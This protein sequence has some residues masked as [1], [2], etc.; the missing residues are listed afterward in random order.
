MN[1]LIKGEQG[2][3]ER[4]EKEEE[5]ITTSCPMANDDKIYLKNSF[6]FAFDELFQAF[7]DLMDEFKKLRLK[8]KE[9][10][11]S[12]L[13]LTEEKNKILIEKEDIMKEI[14]ILVKEKENIANFE[15][16]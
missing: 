9:L 3:E 2:K 11:K 14:K 7:N 13:F 5:R 4:N 1:A 15:N 12:N 8:N 6:D 10:K 16:L